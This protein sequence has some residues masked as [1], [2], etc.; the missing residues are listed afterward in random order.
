[1]KEPMDIGI[2]LRT[3]MIIL[4]RDVAYGAKRICGVTELD[5]LKNRFQ[6]NCIYLSSDQ[7][8]RSVLL[9]IEYDIPRMCDVASPTEGQ[10][11]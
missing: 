6:S 4:N 8:G 7:S 1:M 3:S 10:F 5:V 9:T 11:G 2:I